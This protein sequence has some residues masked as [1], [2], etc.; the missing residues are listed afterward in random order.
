MMPM[1]LSFAW[2]ACRHAWRI[3]VHKAC[4]GWF[5]F[6]A[7]LW[8]RGIVH[9]LSKFHPKEFIP[10]AMWYSPDHSPIIDARKNLGWSEAWIHH[11]GINSHHYEHWVDNIDKGAYLVRMPFEDA[12]EMVCDGLGAVIAYNWKAQECY[13]REWQWWISNQKNFAMHPHTRAFRHAM[14][15]KMREEGNCGALQQDI[16]R[17]EYNVLL[18][19]YEGIPPTVPLKDCMWKEPE[20]MEE[21]KFWSV[22]ND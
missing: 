20:S 4:V 11:K 9:D 22:E 2:N 14:I 18:A 6:H 1:H 5:C 3:L 7:G 10:G 16:A 17:Y 21:R 19:K 12:L 8:W 15:R 13:E